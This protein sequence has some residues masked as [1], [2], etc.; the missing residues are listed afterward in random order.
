[1]NENSYEYDGE[2]IYVIT[3]DGQQ[4]ETVVKAGDQFTSQLIYFSDCILNNRIMDFL[5]TV[6]PN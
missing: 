5:R 2:A 3:I 4:T 6:S 1:M